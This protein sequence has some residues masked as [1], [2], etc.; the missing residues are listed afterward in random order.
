VA[1]VQLKNVKTDD[2]VQQIIALT[3]KQMDETAARQEEEAKT[4]AEVAAQVGT[5]SGK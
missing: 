2:V 4:E 1:G 3:K 5:S